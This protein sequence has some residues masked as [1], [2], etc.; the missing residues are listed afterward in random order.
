I[1]LCF[2]YITSEDNTDEFSILKTVFGLKKD[3]IQDVKLCQSN[4]PDHQTNIYYV[5]RILEDNLDDEE[6]VPEKDKLEEVLERSGFSK[7]KASELS[8]WLRGID[9]FEN[10]RLFY[11]VERYLDFLNDTLPT[12]PY[13]H[14]PQ[15][16]EEKFE[17]PDKYNTTEQP[18]ENDEEYLNIVF[19]NVRNK[20]S[21]FFATNLRFSYI[22][23]P[24]EDGYWYHGTSHKAAQSI[25]D[26]GIDLSKGKEK[27]DFSDGYG[28]YLTPNFKDAKHYALENG[29]PGGSILVFEFNFGKSS[30]LRNA[31]DKPPK[32][33]HLTDDEEG[34]RCVVKHNRTGKAT[35][36]PKHYK[37]AEYVYGPMSNYTRNPSHP[38]KH[39]HFTT[40]QMCIKKDELAIAVRYALKE[41]YFFPSKV[42]KK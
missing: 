6:D 8:Q 20:H 15:K 22:A 42:K 30:L 31:N 5:K 39:N 17:K 12:D 40:P 11:W 34:W 26:I 24:C 9:L 13:P 36:C 14:Q 38:T 33:L 16:I 27:Q 28:F 18:R 23:T 32:G 2:R 10:Q 37:K 3:V 1:R 35:S 29:H 41:I 25:F 4:I 19:V 7:E 21:K